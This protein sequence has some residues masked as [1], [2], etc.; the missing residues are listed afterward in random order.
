M[1]KIKLC[2]L[3]GSK[4]FEF[5]LKGQDKMYPIK[6]DYSLFQCKQCGLIFVN[7][8]P[9]QK[10]L[11]KHYPAEKYYSLGKGGA[12]MKSIL[13]RAYYSEG[14]YL[15]KIA[16]IL[17]KP[18]INSIK[19]VPKGKL[20][21]V[22][23]GSGEFLYL[24]K[25]KGMDCYGIE[26]G[27]FDRKFA[28]SRGLKIFNG[29]LEKAKYQNAYFDVIT[30][31]HVFEHVENPMKTMKE[32]KR[33]LKPNGTLII[34]IPV[35][36]CLAYGVFGKNWIALDIPRHLYIYS[37]K[38]MIEYA[39]K[40]GFRAEKIRYNSGP[41]Q[42]AGSFIYRLGDYR[43]KERY[44]SDISKK[45]FLMAFLYIIGMP[46]AHLCNL[47]KIGDQIEVFLKLKKK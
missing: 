38:I 46:L 42:F 26:P 33:I 31:N 36:G 37:K 1:N 15:S 45:R 30:M 19:I 8:Q 27:K 47:L 18:F 21:D 40:A 34:G 39:K 23:C 29:T 41:L 10:E 28:D 44:F 22:G 35:S 20:L 9:S 3:C 14:N 16:L 12:E 7:P 2:N 4:S 32:L 6:G 43:G 17:F 25:K 13:Q 24:A 5:L 11:E